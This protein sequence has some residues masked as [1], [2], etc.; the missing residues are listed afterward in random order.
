MPGGRAVLAG[1]FSPAHLQRALRLQ[2][3]QIDLTVFT[4]DKRFFDTL[5]RRGRT[6]RHRST[7]CTP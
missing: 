4:N 6:K 7:I 5:C 3:G 2:A 1:V